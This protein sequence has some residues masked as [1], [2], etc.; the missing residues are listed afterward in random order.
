[1]NEKKRLKFQEGMAK[2]GFLEEGETVQAAT[3]GQSAV[4]IWGMVLM[5]LIF[6]PLVFW[7]AFSGRQAILTDRNIYVLKAGFFSAYT[8]QAVLAKHA[9]GSVA[10]F[11]KGGIG[12]ELVVGNDKIYLPWNGTYKTGAEL[13]AAGGQQQAPAQVEPA[14]S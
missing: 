8:P 4:P 7:P 5:V 10:T 1:M 3:Y 6:I 9:I 12:P 14:A 13:I 11:Y 2:A